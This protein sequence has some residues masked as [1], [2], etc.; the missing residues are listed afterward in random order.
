M[1]GPAWNFFLLPVLLL[2]G[3]IPAEL[4]MT[5]QY[6]RRESVKGLHEERGVRLTYSL[7]VDAA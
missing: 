3:W 1:E 2:Y 5:P 4:W 7:K 6:L